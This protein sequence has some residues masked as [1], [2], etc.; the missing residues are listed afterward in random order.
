MI[1][2]NLLPDVKQEYIKTQRMKRLVMTVSF[3]ASAAALFVLLVLLSSV[4]LVQRKS[5][6]DLNNNIGSTNNTFKNI[7]NIGDILTVQSQLNSLSGLH[8]QEPAASRLFG[9][10]TQLTPQQATISDL[11][12][13][14]AQHTMSIS[15]N[16]PSLDVVNTFIDGLKYTNYTVTGQ[17]TMNLAFSTVVLASFSRNQQTAT[18]TITLGFDPTIFDNAKTVTLTVGGQQQTSTQQPSIIFKKSE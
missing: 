2:F 10:L 15:G 12:V 8:A 17:N 16:A 18:Y 11:K 3:V 7:A 1:Q 5:I 14:Y 9:Y 4:Y 13:D 6:H